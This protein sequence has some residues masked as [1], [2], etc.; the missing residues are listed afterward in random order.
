MARSAFT[1]A[2]GIVALVLA[3]GGCGSGSST[4]RPSGPFAQALASVGGGGANGSLGIGWADP[5]LVEDAGLP[6][7]VIEDA[8]GPNAR[9]VVQKRSR[10][11]RRFG[12]DPLSA[13]R[14][15]SVG[16]SYAFGLRL[17]GV[18]AHDLE[19]ALV[20]AGA[21]VRR[22]EELELVEAAGYAVVPQPLL[23]S[24]V[25]GLGAYDAFG[26]SLTV[27]AISQTAREAL[28]GHGERLL[29]EPTYAAA[30]SCLGDVVA[31][32]MIPDNLLL[33]TDLGVNAV[34]IGV[35]GPR[36]ETLCVLGGTA[37][38]AGEVATALRSSLAPN[39]REP[40]TGAPISRS[41][42]QVRVARH[43]YAGIE[44]VQAKLRLAPTGSARFL[45]ETVSHGSL[46][47]MLNAS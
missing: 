34:A 46:P 42:A 29:D 39:A 8:L 23:R 31:V 3:L 30:A 40:V 44:V 24:G 26:R 32:R 7:A 25:T 5:Q 14:L 10:L 45:F 1:A 38:R 6:R 21:R 20:D 16:G 13:R 4:P 11:R 18:D 27:L 12:F 43:R 36:H 15:V 9:T 22:L 33:S 35:S 17:D 19:G 2:T 37:R 41:V 47:R 28:L